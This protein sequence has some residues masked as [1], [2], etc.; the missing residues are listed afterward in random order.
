MNKWGEEYKRKLTTAEEA[1]KS[2]RDGDKLFC[3][4]GSM[5]PTGILDALFDRAEELKDVVFG[6]LIMLA[7]TYKIL[8]EEM[9]RHIKF[10][11][12]YATPLD[13]QALH[14]G[15]SEHTPFHF[16]DLP[17]LASEYAGYKTVITQAGPMDRHGYMSCGVS[18][19]FLDVVH[20][21]D[22]LIVEVNENV[23]TV[24]GRNFWHISQVETVVEHHAPLFPVPPEPVIDVD[25]AIAE[26]IAGYIHDGDTIQLGIGAVPN[27]IGECLLEKKHLGCYTE[28]IPDAIMKLFE[29]GALDNSRKTWYPFQFNAFFSAGSNELYQ[30]LDGNPMVYLSPISYN[31]DPNNVARNDNMVAIN[32]TL[33]ID[34]TGQCASESI[35]PYQYSAT[36]G[37]VDFTRGA[38]MAKGGR[39]FIATHSTAFD[40]ARGEMVSKIVPHLREGA[41]VTLTRTDTMY[42]ATEYGVVNL[43]G[44]TM[45]ERAQALTSIAHPDF[46]GEL[47]QYAKDVKYFIF[48]EHEEACKA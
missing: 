37:Q 29:A 43:K 39:A 14:E 35:G 7:P 47:I 17:R 23:P 33:E 2:I 3:G 34:I 40:K 30:W 26:N 12:L 4:S 36:G 46:K 41:T 45:R 38:Y 5:A 15:I 48:P 1:A 8:S 32:S 10:N 31:N 28:M 22:R 11:N 16:S 21:L 42:V 19:N 20:T 18:G 27:A 9:S 13:R 44:K 6:G 24:Y 25:R